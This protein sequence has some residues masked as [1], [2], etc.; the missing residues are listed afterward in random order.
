[1]Y[2]GGESEVKSHWW[3]KVS[4]IVTAWNNQRQS[5]WKHHS[6]ITAVWSLSHRW[7]G[8]SLWQWLLIVIV[9]CKVWVENTVWTKTLL[10]ILQHHSLT[11]DSQC[12]H[13]KYWKNLD[14]LEDSQHPIV[15]GD[16][17]KTNYRMLNMLCTWAICINNGKDWQWKKN[18]MFKLTIVHSWRVVQAL[19]I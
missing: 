10:D 14:K 19:D 3:N 13:L 16:I 18:L 12:K 5:T 11:R 15:L 4:D 6:I 1:M 9:V 17:V 7:S 8:G 2:R